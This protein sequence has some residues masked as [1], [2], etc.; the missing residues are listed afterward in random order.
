MCVKNVDRHNVFSFT[1]AFHNYF[2]V[3]DISSVYVGQLEGLSY[4]N[5]MA[6]EEIVLGENSF[7]SPYGMAIDRHVDRVYT[8][9][10]LNTNITVSKAKEVEKIISITREGFDTV[11]LW[12]PYGSMDDTFK[13]WKNFIAV[14]SGCVQPE[15][16][17]EPRE[18]FIATQHVH[19]F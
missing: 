7:S 9:T 3:S 15:R 11:T 4:A 16:M 6:G 5:R 17:L 18:E 2:H 1:T 19:I 10:P 12:N 8:N 14:E 13:G